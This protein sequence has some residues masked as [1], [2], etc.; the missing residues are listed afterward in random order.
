MSFMYAGMVVYKDHNEPIRYI[1]RVGY[2]DC[3]PN[4]ERVKNVSGMI[5]VDCGSDMCGIT[6]RADA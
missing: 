2:V 6:I 5:C 3:C 4:S 1:G